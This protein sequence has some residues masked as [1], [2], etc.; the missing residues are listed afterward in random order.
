MGAETVGH[1]NDLCC[2]PLGQSVHLEIEV[3]AAI[4]NYVSDFPK[5]IARSPA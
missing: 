1:P 2:L 4:G 5:A 3:I